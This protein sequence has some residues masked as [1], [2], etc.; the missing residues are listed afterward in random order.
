MT[1]DV[2][3]PRDDSDQVSFRADSQM[4]PQ[5]GPSRG[6]MPSVLLQRV[7]EE[8]RN[9]NKIHVLIIFSAQL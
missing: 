6:T 5:A 9:I 2:L 7:L 4:L 8:Y 1:P 3:T